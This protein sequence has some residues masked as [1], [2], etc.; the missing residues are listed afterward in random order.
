MLTK[1]VDPDDMPHDAA[2]NRGLHCLPDHHIRV[3]STKKDNEYNS[4]FY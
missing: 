2:F 1:S 3:S 4:T